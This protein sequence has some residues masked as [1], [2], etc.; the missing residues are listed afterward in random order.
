MQNDKAFDETN[1]QTI[2]G[3][4]IDFADRIKIKIDDKQVNN[5]FASGCRK[6]SNNILASQ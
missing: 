4:R 5:A 2:D 6:S 1:D 3:I